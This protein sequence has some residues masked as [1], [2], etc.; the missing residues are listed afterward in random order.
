MAAHPA[1]VASR[2]HR[3]GDADAGY[4][5]PGGADRSDSGAGADRPDVSAHGHLQPVSEDA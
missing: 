3:G 1:E 4:G 5:A 2:D